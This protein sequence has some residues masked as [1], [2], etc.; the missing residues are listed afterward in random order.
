M[1]DSFNGI[2]VLLSGMRRVWLL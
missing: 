2:T 1:R